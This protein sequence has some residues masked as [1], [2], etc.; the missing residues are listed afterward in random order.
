[1]QFLG[2]LEVVLEHAGPEPPVDVQKCPGMRRFAVASSC[3]L[4]VFNADKI[5]PEKVAMFEMS[6]EVKANGLFVRVCW[7]GAG[8]V[9]ALSTVGK[10]YVFGFHDQLRPGFL[11]ADN[12]RRATA[13]AG[14]RERLV[15]GYDDGGVEVVKLLNGDCMVVCAKR[16]AAAPIKSVKVAKS[17]IVVL[18]ADSK[19]CVLSDVG[20]SVKEM[21]ASDVEGSFSMVATAEIRDLAAFYSPISESVTVTDF[22][23]YSQVL[24]LNSKVIGM[25]FSW[26]GSILVMLCKNEIAWWSSKTQQVMWFQRK[27]CVHGHAVVLLNNVLL[28]SVDCGIQVYPLLQSTHSNVCLLSSHSQVAE[29]RPTSRGLKKIVHTLD[30]FGHIDFA[31]ADGFERFIAVASSN[32]IGVISRRT[33]RIVELDHDIQHVRAIEWLGERLC[34]VSFDFYS[35]KYTLNVMKMTDKEP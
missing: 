17:R 33:M 28:V 9:C 10:V 29:F 7:V 24:N 2:E 30:D 31:I 26:D 35:S 23:E 18:G 34:A 14:Y 19:V 15:V 25:A 4:S 1:M 22:G 32:Q 11:M 5:V 27:E 20:D 3:S 12:V 13:I 16:V 6:D 8:L 21:V